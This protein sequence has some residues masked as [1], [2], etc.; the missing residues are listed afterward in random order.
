MRFGIPVAQEGFIGK[1]ND[2]V[3]V[4]PGF[5]FVY[6]S[7][8]DRG[9]AGF[10]VP[11]LMRWDFFFTREWTVFGSVGPVL[12]FWLDRDGGRNFEVR[13][14]D[15]FRPGGPPGFFGIAFGGGA[16][17]NFSPDTSLRL[18]ASTGMIAVGILFRL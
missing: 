6:W 4:E 2:A 18:D 17:Y 5:Q 11:I 7:D 9:Q 14:K 3:F 10:Q 13:G 8:F 16:F 15:V 1:I 12:G